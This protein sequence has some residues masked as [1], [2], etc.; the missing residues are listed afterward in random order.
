M[1]RL[2]EEAIRDGVK[3]TTRYRSKQPNKRGHR[4]HHPLPQRQA[5]GAKGG[6]ASR[7]SARMRRGNQMPSGSYRSEP[8]RSIPARYES[9][10]ADD[11]VPPTSFVPNTASYYNSPAESELEFSREFGSTLG[12]SNISIYNNRS[13]CGT[14]LSHQSTTFGDSAFIELPLNTADPLFTNSPS[15]TADEPR[16]PDSQNA[17]WANDVAMAEDGSEFIFDV[18]YSEFPV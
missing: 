11:F 4:S 16:T 3:S 17:G 9:F 14:P 8:Y 2:T 1:W 5:S 12:A 10:A 7:R 18:G 6:Q 15:P 13:Y